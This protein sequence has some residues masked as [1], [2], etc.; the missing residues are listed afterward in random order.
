MPAVAVALLTLLLAA[1]L[2]P[3][4]SVIEETESGGQRLKL[5]FACQW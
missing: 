5:V 3:A 1:L 4:D 2:R